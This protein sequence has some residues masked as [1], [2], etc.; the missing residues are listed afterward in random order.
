MNMRLAAVQLRREITQM[1]LAEKKRINA[2]RSQVLAKQADQN[3][4]A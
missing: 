3:K 1:R 4:S 2:T